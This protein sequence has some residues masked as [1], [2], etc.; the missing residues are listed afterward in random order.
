M[1]LNSCSIESKCCG[2]TNTLHQIVEKQPDSYGHFNPV[3][4]MHCIKPFWLDITMIRSSGLVPALISP[5]IRLLP[6]PRP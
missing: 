3:C 1:N 6:L 2:L 4:F 5:R